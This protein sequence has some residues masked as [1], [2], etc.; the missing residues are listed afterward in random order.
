MDMY[1]DP[2]R[3]LETNWDSVSDASLQGG[4][5]NLPITISVWD[6]E[7]VSTGRLDSILELRDALEEGYIGIGP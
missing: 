3:F 2:A 5:F 1:F 7:A 6:D 4:F